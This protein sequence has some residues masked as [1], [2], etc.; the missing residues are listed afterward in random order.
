[1]INH[2]NI[3]ELK[4]NPDLGILFIGKNRCP[5]KNNNIF[6]TLTLLERAV[7]FHGFDSSFMW[8]IELGGLTLPSYLHAVPARPAARNRAMARGFRKNWILV[9]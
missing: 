8:L 6:E 1:I 3:P 7:A 2:D 9:A 5:I 4:K